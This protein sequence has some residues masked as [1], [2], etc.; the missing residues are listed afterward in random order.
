M[1]PR[2]SR[3]HSTH[4]P[5]ESIT[6]STPQVRRPARCHA[7]MG[8]VPAVPRR[9]KAGR[10]S[11]THRSSMPPVPKVAFASPGRVQPCPTSDACWSPAMPHTT[12][13]P[14]NAVAAPTAP[15][16]ST[17]AGSTVGGMRRASRMAWSHPDPSAASSP[18]TPALVASVTCSAPPDSVHTTQESTVPTHRSRVRSGSAMSRSMDTL[19]AD[20]LG[21]TR[22]PCSRRTRQVP[23][24]RRSC[25]PMPGPT[26]SPVLRSHTIVE[27]R[28]LAMP[29]PSTGPPSPSAPAATSSTA[30]AMARASNS[31]KP[32]AGDDG[33]T[34]TC[35]PCSTA[36]S[37]RT[38]AARTP[39]VPTSTTRM[40]LTASGPLRTVTAGRACR[41]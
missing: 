25:H 7:T 18:V 16:E 1:M 31:T 40:P 19:V 6:A 10:P 29:T 5:A 2:S 14:V 23:T 39:E 41:G 26:G 11:P 17:M 22:R 28:W 38:T 4:V 20:S 9:A 27:A 13:D 12:G 30:S 8:K 36:P 15:D 37:G 32:G 21:A 35:R 34:G 24:V 3:S 33:S